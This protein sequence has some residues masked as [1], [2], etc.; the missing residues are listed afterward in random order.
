MRFSQQF[1]DELRDRVTI[2]EVIGRRVTWDRKKTNP[3][4]GDYWACC[5]FHGEKS[6]SF[7]CEDRKGRYHCFGCGVSG[8]HFR[9]LMELD[10]LGF[11]EAIQQVADIA[12]VALPAPDPE[13]ERRERERHNLFD[14]ME[15]AT[16]FF[17]DQLQSAGGA[18]ARAYL[19][20]RGLTGRTIETFRLGYASDSR[21]A[22]KE[23]LA[24]KGVAKEQI[25]ACGLVV[26]GPDVPV[27]YDRFRDRIMFP[28]LS[29]R[30]KVI[31]FGGRAL[32]PDAPAKYLNSN[33]TE[34][35]SKGQ[36]LFNFARAR[37]AMGTDGSGTVIVVE[38]YM[39]VIALAQAGVENA[40]APLG[41][42]L[43][44]DQLQLLWK[45]TSVPVLCFDGDGAG[46]RAASRA[47]DIALP[48]LKPGQSLRIAL[49]PDG[50]DPDDLVRVE[51]RA[52]FDKVISEARAMAD[53]VWLRETSG[54]VFETPERRAELEARLKQVTQVI[55]DESVR[56]HY[57]QDMRD[58][59]YAFFRPANQ[60]SNEQRR[61]FTQ[62]GPQNGR[63]QQPPG[64]GRSAPISDRLA[65]TGLVA[66]YSGMPSLRECALVMTIVNHPA[67][68]FEDFEALHQIEFE[69][70]DMRQFW[71]A[72]MGVA[73][74]SG[75]DLT[76]EELLTALETQGFDALLASLDKQI[77]FARLWTATE[78][79]AIEDAR[80]GYQ[81][82]LALQTRARALLRQRHEIERELAEAVED[83]AEVDSERLMLTLKEVQQEITRL[84]NQEA[85]VDGF[86]VMSG[87]VKGPA[88]GGH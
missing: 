48:M 37:R 49:L 11:N 86:G 34:L 76:R 69:S 27:S 71:Q 9:F 80:E 52:P 2:S 5:P 77:R 8:D 19:R 58:R 1:L 33:E 3:G 4:R 54:T 51:G 18:K 70:R 68:F 56:R 44:E 64:L 88:G 47:V 24:S 60:S 53:M 61:P 29:S 85:L 20:D 38:G 74:A 65:R 39:D 46:M 21:N 43:T 26:H 63:P 79:A 72:M 57:Q 87:R 73:A 50:K 55:G 35:F 36:V 17:Q 25:E 81:Q 83:S 40:V 75:P 13:T 31:A 66:G 41:T 30:E 45:M 28:I 62:R 32:S 7:H 12:G 82:A 42:A 59:L 22:L 67:L 10:G 23:F 15:L 6:P 14:V 16:R 84:E 78:H